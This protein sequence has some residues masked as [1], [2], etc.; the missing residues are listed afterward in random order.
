MTEIEQKIRQFPEVTMLVT[1]LGES[2]GRQA[3][4][5][6]DVTK[7]S[8]YVKLRELEDRA[9]SY[10]RATI[11]L[12]KLGLGHPTNL[13]QWG[14]WWDQVKARQKASPGSVNFTQFEVMAKARKLMLGYPDLRVSVQIP[15]L[16]SGGG[17]V[18]ADVEFAITGPDL[19]RLIEYSEQLMTRLRTTPGFADVDT[20]LALRKPEVRVN[21]DQIG[22]AHV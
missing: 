5:Q 1:N 7:A 22:R 15:Q 17:F 20:T 6:G 3:R 9:F 16:V 10:R 18:N 11:D 12:I 4:A 21:I 13:F 2:G 8:I 14:N 19:N